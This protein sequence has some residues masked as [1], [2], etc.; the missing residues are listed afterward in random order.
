MFNIELVK[1]Y[2]H[3]DMINKY[4]WGVIESNIIYDEVL[5]CYI[6][7]S[8]DWCFYISENGELLQFELMV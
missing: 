3:E 8:V 2:I 4:D 7:S 1:D 5:D 6:V